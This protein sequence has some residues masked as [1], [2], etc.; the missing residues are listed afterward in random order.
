MYR[1][2]KISGRLRKTS[3]QRPATNASTGLRD[4]RASAS[5]SP[6]T[7]ETSIAM[8]AISRLIRKPSRMYRA[9]FP[10]INHSQLSGSNR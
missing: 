3:T 6:T 10:V 2:R 5:S 8:I 7:S 1:I 9:L 4:S